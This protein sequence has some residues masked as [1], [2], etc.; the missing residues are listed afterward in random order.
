MT[1]ETTNTVTPIQAPDLFYQQLGQNSANAAQAIASS[2]PSSL[3]VAYDEFTRREVNRS[4]ERMHQYELEKELLVRER[5]EKN[6]ERSAVMVN[7]DFKQEEIK[8][9]RMALAK[10]RDGIPQPDYL[11]IA[12][13]GF[14]IVLLTLFLFTFYSSTG[15]SAFFG[16]PKES[17]SEIIISN[18]FG[19]A[20]SNGSGALSFVIL[21]PIIFL[22]MGFIVHLS[23]ERKQYMLLAAILL[24]TLVF[25]LFM[26]Y[27]ITENF[28]NKIANRT[29]SEM[30]PWEWTMA[31][32]NINFYIII[33]AGFV[34]YIIWGFLLNFTLKEW[35]RIQ[36]D[37][38]RREQIAELQGQVL[39]ATAEFASLENQL[40]QTDERLT[41]IVASIEQKNN[42]INT[43]KG[44]GIV[45]DTT[46]LQGMV[47]KFM[48]GWRAAITAMGIFNPAFPT[49][50]L[51]D[52]ATEVSDTWLVNK[53][54][55]LES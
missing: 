52:E 12:I 27:K 53:L 30:A 39:Q 45:V 7:R 17:I 31:F 44:G 35:Q 9:K 33:A 37:N 14:I 11:P 3:H 26:A 20:R 41:Q 2:L 38:L 5:G 34:V 18:V 55:T 49:T 16:I 54:E 21:F 6:G 51:M 32:T 22:A 24:F 19:E 36:P 4:T 28:Y 46:A 29:S 40:S 50:Q 43:L 48:E 8:D 1:P 42:R 47:G 15:Y 13:G 10:V 23:I 25:D